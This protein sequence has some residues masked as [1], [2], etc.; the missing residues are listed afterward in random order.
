MRLMNKRTEA[1]VLLYRLIWSPSPVAFM[2]I[3]KTYETPCTKW[4]LPGPNQITPIKQVR[5]ADP[6]IPKLCGLSEESPILRLS[7]IGWS[8]SS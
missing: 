2:E 1:C 6:T 4:W 5:N 7:K 3:L 8:E